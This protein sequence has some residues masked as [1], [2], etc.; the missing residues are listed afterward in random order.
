MPTLQTAH[1][2]TSQQSGESIIVLLISGSVIGAAAGGAMAGWVMITSLLNGNG[3]LTPVQLIA[4]TFF[5][6]GALTLT[7]LV[8]ISGLLLHM[9]TSMILGAMIGLVLSRTMPLWASML[10]GVL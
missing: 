2:Q 7:P 8:F 6:E 10:V 9:A 5:G 4:A 3:F 1:V